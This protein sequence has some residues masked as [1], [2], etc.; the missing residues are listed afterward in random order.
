MTM[1]PI[2][3]FGFIDEPQFRAPDNRAHAAWLLRTYRRKHAMYRIT[4]AGIGQ[5]LIQLRM[6]DAPTAL[7]ITRE[8]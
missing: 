2:P 6:S 7:L 5:Y 1:K 3:T 8:V 4:R